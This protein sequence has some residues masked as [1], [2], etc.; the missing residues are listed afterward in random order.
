MIWI[1]SPAILSAVVASLSLP[2]F[3]L[4]VAC[5]PWRPRSPMR[6]FLSAAALACCL[7][8]VLLLAH[9]APEWPDLLA[10]LILLTASLLAGYTLWTLIVWGFT[11]AMLNVLEQRQR[12]GS[13]EGWC[14]AYAGD[15][16]IDAFTLNRCSLLLAAGFAR[17]ASS[18]ELSITPRG[19]LAAQFVT[20]VRWIFGLDKP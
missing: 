6:H 13:I 18:R 5:G 1:P 4:L 3:L 12:V 2:L 8:T 9:E 16:G 7:M 15:E 20:A 11:L 19:R 10:G 17:L 14:T